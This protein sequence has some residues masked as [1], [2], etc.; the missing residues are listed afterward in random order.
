M[1]YDKKGPPSD[2][3]SF[4]YY[5]SQVLPKCLHQWHWHKWKR[6]FFVGGVFLPSRILQSRSVYWSVWGEEFRNR[7]EFST[8]KTYCQMPGISSIEDLLLCRWKQHWKRHWSGQRRLAL[9]E[10]HSA[11]KWARRQTLAAGNSRTSTLSFDSISPECAR[12]WAAYMA[13]PLEES[14]A[15]VHK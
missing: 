1:R 14:L 5:V 6:M 11:V 10:S 9:C 4:T 15:V 8:Y 3:T 13:F 7:L 2:A 12:W